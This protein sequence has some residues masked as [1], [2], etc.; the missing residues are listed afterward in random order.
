MQVMN[1]TDHVLRFSPAH[2][3]TPLPRIPVGSPGGRDR[4]RTHSAGHT[5]SRSE[6][7]AMWN[8]RLQHVNLTGNRA[9]TT[10]LPVGASC[11]SQASGMP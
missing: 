3:A 5:V 10:S 11:A 6:P 7:G 2:S 8:P 9:G 1:R 4:P